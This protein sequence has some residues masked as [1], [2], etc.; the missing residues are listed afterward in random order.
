VSERERASDHVTPYDRCAWSADEIESALTS[1]TRAAELSAYFGAAEYRALAS[2]ARR[3]ARTPVRAAALRVLLVPGIM[4]SQLGLTRPQPLPPDILWIDPLDFQRG[5]L[6]ALRLQEPS[7]VVALGVVLFSYLRLRLQLRARGF[8]VEF[9]DY[10]WRR[11]LAPL[12]TELAARLR[13]RAPARVAVVAH[14]M[15]GLL[16]RAALVEQGLEHVQRVVLLGTPNSGSFAAVQALRG[17][18]AVVRKLARLVPD[19]SAETLTEEVFSSFASLYELLPRPPLAR[20]RELFA[21]A[22]WPTLG[23]RPNPALLDAARDS[24]VRLAAA[25]ERFT[26]IAGTGAETVTGL[27]RVRG[28]F[29]YT[30]TR[31]GDGTVPAASA[32]LPGAQ[33]AYARVAHSELTRDPQVAA[34]VAD[35]LRTGSTRRLPA[36]ERSSSRAR[37]RVSDAALRRTHTEKVDWVALSPEERRTFLENL[38]EPPHLRLRVP[39][40][41]ARRHR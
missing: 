1:G 17:T 8:A 6:V 9:H 32:V 7:R 18:Y 41:A 27:A 3:A 37:V 2:L 38:N 33:A 29:V 5:R 26:C 24:A 30:L 36:R 10:D 28:Q 15:G 19:R 14:S 12:G 21:A 31:H 16:A 34:A 4:G 25:D 23:P 40:R 22:S 20:G 35:V 39:R 11:S 13:A